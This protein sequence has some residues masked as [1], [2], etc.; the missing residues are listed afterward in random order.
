MTR[1]ADWEAAAEMFMSA[2][3]KRLGGPPTPDEVVAYLRGE[4][5]PREAA[6]VRSLLVYYPELTDLL[7]DSEPAD[8]AA[9]VLTEDELEA[10]RA[11]LHRR[12]A[13]SNVVIQ[14][15]RPAR[16]YH[17]WLAAAAASLVIAVPV[18]QWQY[19]RSLERE[20]SEPQVQEAR[21]QLTA[22]HPRGDPAPAQPTITLPADKDAYLLE[23]NVAGAPPYADYRIALVAADEQ[24]P[25][26][27]WTKSGVRPQDDTI[28]LTVR[29]SFLEPGRYRL[30]VYCSDG[31]R[32]QFLDRHWIEVPKS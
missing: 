30:D 22:L 1:K 8:G 9:E 24:P 26:T 18:A 23:L 12:I 11:A 27:L 2:E 16:R 28:H 5:P 19:A 29:R 13:L 32:Q 21:V 15:L 17:A 6:R 14:P 10:N 20:L 31:S 25:R 7:S 3:R 4:L